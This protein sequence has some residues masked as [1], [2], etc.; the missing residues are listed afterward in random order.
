MTQSLPE[1]S[2]ELN[3]R[4]DQRQQMNADLQGTTR[5]LYWSAQLA[6]ISAA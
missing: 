6:M 4:Q 3:K 2:F 5:I 1:K